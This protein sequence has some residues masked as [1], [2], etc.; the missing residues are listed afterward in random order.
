M[1]VGTRENTISLI[2]PIKPGVILHMQRNC[3][4][5]MFNMPEGEA[6][7][8]EWVWRQCSSLPAWKHLYHQQ[9][10][11]QG[12][13]PLVFPLC[14]YCIP[15]CMRWKEVLFVLAGVKLGDHRGWLGHHV[16]SAEHPQQLLRRGTLPCNEC[17]MTLQTFWGQNITKYDDISTTFFS[18]KPILTDDSYL[19]LEA[20]T[21]HFNHLKIIFLNLEITIWRSNQTD[22]GLVIIFSVFQVFGDMQQLTE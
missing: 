5:W 6:P 1:H 19:I 11:T 18:F 10:A 22:N 15:L 17:S 7:G 3:C 16:P 4:D 13:P 21:D 9:C 20:D 12:Q 14:V 2:A 8:G